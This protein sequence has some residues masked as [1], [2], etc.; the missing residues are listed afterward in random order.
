VI[1]IDVPAVGWSSEVEGLAGF[2]R[3]TAEDADDPEISWEGSHRCP[4]VLQLK[5]E[6]TVLLKM[7]PFPYQPPLL[8]S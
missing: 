4:E 5:K 8:I 6:T 1:W 3:N 7:Q 2:S